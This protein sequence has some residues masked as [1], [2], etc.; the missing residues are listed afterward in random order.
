[1][2]G[3]LWPIDDQLTEPLMLALHRVYR[4]RGD[5][6]AALREAQLMMLH[7]TDSAQ[8]SPSAWAAFRYVGT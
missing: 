2:V 6:S 5:A 8:R 1:M 3:S 7:S 4:R